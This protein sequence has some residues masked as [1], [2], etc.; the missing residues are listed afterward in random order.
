[1]SHALIAAASQTLFKKPISVVSK[2]GA[3]TPPLFHKIQAKVPIDT[4]LLFHYYLRVFESPTQISPYIHSQ[5][6]VVGD[7]LCVL[8]F[9][10]GAMINGAC[11]YWDLTQEEERR[12]AQQEAIRAAMRKEMELHREMELEERSRA[13]FSREVQEQRRR[14]LMGNKIFFQ[15]R[16]NKNSASSVNAAEKPPSPTTVADFILEKDNLGNG[17]T[18]KKA[19]AYY[20]APCERM[21]YSRLPGEFLRQSS[22]ASSRAMSS[23]MDSDS[24][25]LE[26][27]DIFLE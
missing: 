22:V 6:M 18:N 21:S 2:L 5:K 20:V 10:S 1:L 17:A 13:S 9:V 8:N 14:Q 23:L 4:I 26:L 19:Q 27:E 7:P 15:I 11:C 16:S 24:E 25:D 12:K 3:P